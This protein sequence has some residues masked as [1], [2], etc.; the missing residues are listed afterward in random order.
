[1]PATDNEPAVGG[2]RLDAFVSY[3]RLPG[4]TAFV[5]RLQEALRARG[6]QLWVDRTEIEP[7]ADSWARIARGIRAAKA[8]IFVI[9]P[10]SVVSE[11]CQRELDTAVSLNKLIIPLVLRD[12]DPRGV[13]ERLAAPN[14]IF[15]TPDRDFEESL[16][17]VLR[18]L[19]NDVGWRDDHARLAVRAEEWDQSNR[20]R[21]F[22]L[23][24]LDLRS[25]QEWLAHA[26]EHEQ[27]PPTDLQVKY[28]LTSR[29]T[30]IRTRRT[31]R[32]VLVTVLA[33]VLG[34][35]AYG[36][37]QSRRVS[38]E[39]QQARHQS[40]AA[41]TRQLIN[42]SE[43]LGDA[44]PVLAEQES[45]AAW[46]IDPSAQAQYAMLNSATSP[47]GTVFATSGMVEGLAFGAGGATLA[48]ASINGNV[49]RW[50]V[51][52]GQ[53]IG[54]SFRV[55]IPG[56]QSDQ[57]FA[58]DAGLVA[59]TG[60]GSTLHVWD[61]ATR[62]LIGRLSSVVNP[63]TDWVALNAD[64]T[65]AATG[66]SDG[67]AQVW[68]VA[69]GQQIGSNLKVSPM[70]LN[71]DGRILA[72]GDGPEAIQLW[73]TDSGQRIG[74][75]LD[76]GAAVP[77]V[78]AF[79]P[80]GKILAVGSYNS[81]LLFSVATRTLI[82][83]PVAS[84]WVRS[85]A[86][87]QEG[88]TLAGGTEDG[89]VMLWNVTTQQ[90]MGSTLTGNN[91]GG[92]VQAV[93]FSP[94]GTLATGSYNGSIR[95]WDVGIQ[96]PAAVPMPASSSSSVRVLNADGKTWAT[97]SSNGT[98]QLWDVATRRPTGTPFT[99]GGVNDQVLFSLNG[100]YLAALTKSSADPIQVWDLATGQ[101]IGGVPLSASAMAI[102]PDGKTLAVATSGGT[103]QLWD[104]ATRHP[105]GNSF[106]VSPEV[107][108]SLAFSPNGKTLATGSNDDT[109]RLWDVATH[110]QI[111]NPLTTSNWVFALAFSPDGKT[112]ATG[113]ISDGTVR[114]WDVATDQQIGSTLDTGFG[115]VGS[116]AFSPDG[117][118]LAVSGLNSSTMQRWNVRYLVNTAQYL[119]T[120]VNNQSMARS[121]W[122]LNA[123]GVPYQST[124]P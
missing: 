73:D 110:R 44:N 83:S 45:L 24:G 109:A 49:E 4:D 103:V 48:A 30:A 17:L 101:K 105:I 106:T 64:G 111:G 59:G 84:G 79:S 60:P 65:V 6:K 22:L 40:D 5:D 20:D 102:S 70:A 37:T 99:G 14:W 82:G 27:V 116:M 9:T 71:P 115:N 21:G 81:I 118:T 89:T 33:V 113:S 75:P 119:C 39:G 43:A 122:E 10:E 12:T 23:R 54:S 11:Q 124:C 85:L 1:L 96:Q 38:A 7:A 19:D 93:A 50:D 90:Q 53:Q 121:E 31:W 18:A 87:S 86:F 120:L 72:A 51:A 100:K 15:F 63:S 98:F 62:H 55:V 61:L 112:L 69:T 97:E 34:L 13:D 88:M 25:A 117:K 41:A 32:T 8:F 52:T 67:K 76:T 26:A 2:P 66:A 56:F 28:I 74:G 58:A 78:A 36:L 108:Y 95:L 114:L 104:V 3:R 91:T 80:N 46:R 47:G 123:P 42:D 77:L 94:D 57:A 16:G 92:P 35:G 29:K 68:N 107:I